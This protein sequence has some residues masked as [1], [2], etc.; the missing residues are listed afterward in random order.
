MQCEE[1][2]TELLA[3]KEEYHKLKD[4]EGKPKKKH[5]RTVDKSSKRIH[6]LV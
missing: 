6:M 3:L 5:N 2:E 1:A 4:A